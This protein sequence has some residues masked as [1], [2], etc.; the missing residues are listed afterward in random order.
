MNDLVYELFYPVLQTPPLKLHRYK[1]VAA[2]HRIHGLLPLWADQRA[3]TGLAGF[4]SYR[5]FIWLVVLI[6]Q[7]LACSPNHTTFKARKHSYSTNLHQH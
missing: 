1:L 4:E 2:H 7:H 3:S 6:T 5:I